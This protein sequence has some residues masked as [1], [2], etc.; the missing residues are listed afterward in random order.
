MYAWCKQDTYNAANHSIHVR[1]HGIVVPLFIV[2]LPPVFV[3]KLQ[4]GLHW[5]VAA[6]TT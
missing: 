5:P 1:Q 2:L 4:W 6:M 3:G